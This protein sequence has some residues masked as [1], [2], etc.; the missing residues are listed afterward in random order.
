[1]RKPWLAAAALL[2][3]TLPVRSAE[4]DKLL[5]GD[6]EGVLVVNVRQLLDSAVI[7]KYALEMMKGA[8]ENEERVAKPLAAAGI[9]PFKDVDSIMLTASGDP[10]DNK[11]LVVVR[12]RFNKDRIQKTADD[13]AKNSDGKL[14]VHTDGGVRIYE[15]MGNDADGKPAFLAFVDDKTLVASPSKEYTAEVVKGEVRNLGKPSQS[16]K[17]ALEKVEGKD[18]LWLALV[19]TEQMKK[20]MGRN[21]QTAQIANKLESVTGT[22]NLTDFMLATIMI[23]T[24]D[25]EAAG[26]VQMLVNNFKPFLQVLAQANEDAAPIVNE[27]LNNLKVEKTKNSVSISLKVTEDI[28]KKLNK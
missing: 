20:Q 16:M 11:M 28:A 13:L 2:A 5:P 6:S 19:I 17:S 22:I 10:K 27:L 21:P 15:A 18:S 26:Q 25:A 1:M 23:H 24:A 12:G 8:L 14:T 7:K 3:L 4:A 9:D